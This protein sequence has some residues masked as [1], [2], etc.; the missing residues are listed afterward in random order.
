M[1]ETKNSLGLT[2]SEINSIKVISDFL[3]YDQY[4]DMASYPRF[5]ECIGCFFNNSKDEKSQKERITYLEQIFQEICGEKRKYITFRRMIKS[6]IKYKNNKLSKISQKFFKNLFE[7][8]Y[9]KEGQ[10]LGKHIDKSIKFE[11]KNGKKLKSISKFC[12]ITDKNKEKI[13]GF[14]I[15]YDDFFKN[16]LFLNKSE[17]NYY[18]SLEI[19]LNVLDNINEDEKNNFPNIDNRDGITH[20]FGTYNNKENFISFMGFKC[21]TGKTSY[22]GKPDGMPFLF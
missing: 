14:R 1:S 6:Y 17:E 10:C 15:Y 18:V 7:N 13:K 5:E 19:N 11:I 3:F 4:K 20:I 9:L 22:I 2:Y 16:D 21:M 12:V 8:L